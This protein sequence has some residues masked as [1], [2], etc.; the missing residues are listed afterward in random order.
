MNARLRKK[1]HKHG[2]EL[3]RS[4]KHVYQLDKR[5]GKSYWRDGIKKDMKNLLTAF[6]ILELG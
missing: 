6:E 3:P 1:T 5:N 2:V 4:V